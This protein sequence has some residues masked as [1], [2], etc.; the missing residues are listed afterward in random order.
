MDV[1]F[2]EMR[3]DVGLDEVEERPVVLV[4][5]EEALEGQQLARL[6]AQCQLL[7]Q[8][9]HLAVDLQKVHV[10]GSYLGVAVVDLPHHPNASR[11][12]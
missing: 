2:V 11:V 8:L 6:Q 7:L 5:Q 1:V 3:E 9:L 4:L 12:V 10:Y